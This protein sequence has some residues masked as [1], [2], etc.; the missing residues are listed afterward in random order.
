[1]KWHLTFLLVLLFATPG[2]AREVSF[3]WEPMEGAIGY[4]I[5]VSKTDDFKTPFLTQKLQTP[6]FSSPMEPGKYFYRVRVIDQAQHP[7]KW[8]NAA[9]VTI[10]SPAPELITPASGFETSYYERVPEIAF[11][12]KSVDITASYEIVIIDS[13]GTE[14][15]RTTA[16]KSDYKGSLPGGEYQWQ[17]RSLGKSPIPGREGS[18]EEV[19]SEYSKPW[20]FKIIKNN[21]DKPTLI[22]PLNGAKLFNRSPI[23]FSWNQDPHTHFADVNIEELDVDKPENLK[24][25]KIAD[26]EV[27]KSIEKPGHYR[28]SVTS[29]EEATT[30]GVTSETREFNILEDPLFAGNY[31]L[32]LNTS[33]SNDVYL[34]NSSLQIQTPQQV[35]QQSSSYGMH[36]GLSLGYYIFRGFGFFVSAREAPLLTENLN[37]AQKELDGQMR[38]R[39]GANGFFQEF[40]FGYRQMDIIEAENTPVSQAVDLNT[41]GP[42]FGT[43]ISV[44]LSSR[45]K[46]QG[47]GFY[48]KPLTFSSPQIAT[49]G[50]TNADVMG[51]SLGLKWNFSGR[52]WA[53]YRFAIERVNAQMGMP[54]TPPY[55]NSTWGLFRTE[56]IFLSISYE[57]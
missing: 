50:P 1:M 32:E 44:E 23:N 8:S 25:D 14:I 57:R 37:T 47:T 16:D 22:A 38:F 2:L 21:L 12:W 18:V 31:E 35:G 36:Y 11:T 28:W 5:Q 33:Y 13:A 6:S 34:T 41:T 51:G 30:P 48:Y 53:G 10:A 43:R 42:L 15:V 9:P 54:L 26:K 3:S 55:V 29:K 4:E 17:V 24:F 39:Y 52:F 46:I 27:K 45:L 49:L 40:W 20:H 56:P 19:P 7:G